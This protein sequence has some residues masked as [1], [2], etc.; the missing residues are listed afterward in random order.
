[1][2]RPAQTGKKPELAKLIFSGGRHRSCGTHDAPVGIQ[3]GDIGIGRQRQQLLAKHTTRAGSRPAPRRQTLRG[4]KTGFKLALDIHT[5]KVGTGKQGLMFVPKPV[6]DIDL[7]QPP[8]R[9]AE[10]QDDDQQESGKITR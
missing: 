10:R 1:M 2:L 7:E 3:Q 4:G 9:Q 5:H 6:I 8:Q